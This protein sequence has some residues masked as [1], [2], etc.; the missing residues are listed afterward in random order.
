MAE[1]QQPVS[2]SRVGEQDRREGRRGRRLTD[3]LA[4]LS[5]VADIGLMKAAKALSEMAGIPI[6]TLAAQVR[7]VPLTAVPT[8]VGGSEVVVAGV[9]LGITGDISGHIILMLSVE[10]ACSLA[11]MLLET[12]VEPSTELDEMTQSALAE[13]GNVTG[14]F[15]LSAL[16]DACSMTILPTPP[17]VVVDMGGAI[18]D[19]VLA[20]LGEESSDDVFAIDT[21]FKQRDAKVDAFFIVL[22]RQ[23]DMQVLLD[24]LPK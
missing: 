11:S 9:Y 14:S 1:S 2:L 23:A 6:E 7:K 16:A 19:A 10:E 20:A 18:L 22:P 8:M 15:F 17:T 21:I 4:A 13:M 24:K 12:P 3:T 5:V